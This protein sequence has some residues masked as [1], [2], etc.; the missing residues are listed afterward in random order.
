[1]KSKQKLSV[2]LLLIIGTLVFVS[3]LSSK[4]Y[5]RIDLTADKR[6]TLSQATKDIIVNLNEPVTIK[7]YFSGNLPNQFDIIKRD[8]R[9]MLIEYNSA[10]RGSVVY[11][12]LDP[13]GDTDIQREA[14]QNGVM[15][16][17]IQV[18]DHKNNQVSA[19]SAFFGAV[20]QMGDRKEI[21]PVVV[22]TEGMEYSLT[23]AIK[24]LA[25]LDKPLVGLLRG[26]GEAGTSKIRPAMRDLEVL[27]SVEEVI[28]NDSTEQLSKYSTVVILGPTDSI[29]QN[30][31]DQ[32]TNY[33]TNGGRMLVALNRVTADLN[34]AYTQSE[35]INT[36][37]ETW[38]N[39][40]GI[41]VNQNY[42]MDNNCV[43]TMAQVQQQGF[44]NFIPITL[45]F[46]ATLTN[47]SEHPVAGGL[48]AIQFQFISTINYSGDSNVTFTPLIR[49]SEYS[50]TESAGSYIEL[51]K[52]YSEA[53]FPLS[54]MVVAAAFEGPIGGSINNKMV[55]IG[56]ADFP[57]S[58]GQQ[59]QQ[60]NPDSRGL[61]VNAVDWLSD[62]TGLIALRTQGA[63]MR[64]I[65]EME[66][67]RKNF[68][69]YF[70]F[71]FPLLLAIG[72]GIFRFQRNRIRSLKRREVGY[73]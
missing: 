2:S 8:F 21:L 55:V 60:D 67:S 31:L 61:L 33:V 34:S 23:S 66:D 17:H 16:R 25:V 1:M 27:Y 50:S 38:L 73:V 28:L 22:S 36:G 35:A 13:H 6:Y 40:Y 32:L 43:R 24:K 12:F 5:F 20:V 51:T 11:E 56:D 64:P 41:E 48:E 29:P 4:Y 30:H 49:S 69:K 68:L 10:S 39:N 72:Y 18:E 7:A 52:E 65:K 42:L 9:D 15:E 57:V 62:D 45:P 14:Q 19:Q 54:N 63:T 70:N 58:E 26:H 37:L 46:Y 59:Q 44:V 71:G 53:D 3:I 47:F